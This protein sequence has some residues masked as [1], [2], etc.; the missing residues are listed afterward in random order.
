ME[1]SEQVKKPL[2]RVLGLKKYY[3]VKK[4]IFKKHVGDVKAVDGIDL[5]IYP[6]EVVGLVGESGCGKSTAGR[7]IIRL[8][9]PTSGEIMFLEKNFL[10]LQGDEL[11]QM[12]QHA[13]I[14]FQDPYSSLN[15]RLTVGESIGEALL[16]HGIVKDRKEQ[17]EYV[18]EV[19][20]LIG[21]DPHMMD[22]YP[23]QFSG[24]QQQRLCIGRAI[25]LKPKLI[26]CDEVVSALDVSI[27]AQILNL[28][29]ELKEKFDLSYLFISHDLSV[30]R[31]VCDRVLVMYFGKIVES[32]P[33]GEIFNHPQNAYTKTLLKS[34]LKNSR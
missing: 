22:R 18:A 1:N 9:E 17:R 13:Q 32:A 4:G 6:G 29:I 23:H 28:L 14:I 25:A 5:E 33:T 26:I 31:H 27:Q 11:R 19:M 34:I 10:S 16:Y 21:M 24:G 7:S 8:I 3:P 2:L 15:P 20:K 30:V 12:R